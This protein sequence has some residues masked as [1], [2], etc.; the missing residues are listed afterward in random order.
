MNIAIVD[1]QKEYR[2]LIVQRLSKISEFEINTY[3]FEDTS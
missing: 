1:D 2:E 3:S